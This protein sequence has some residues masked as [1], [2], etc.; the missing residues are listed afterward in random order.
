MLHRLLIGLTLPS[1]CWTLTLTGWGEL[2][3]IAA[4][5][6]LSKL[7]VLTT[8]RFLI[9]FEIQIPARSHARQGF[10]VGQNTIGRGPAV[11]VLEFPCRIDP[12]L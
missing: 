1:G 6:Y 7:F 8:P 11:L 2:T 3:E 4:K 9:L 12:H 10:E 5:G